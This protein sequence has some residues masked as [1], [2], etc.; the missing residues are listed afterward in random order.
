[1]PFRCARGAFTKNE[2][3]R[4]EEL[5]AD[6]TLQLVMERDGIT[7]DIL[8]A[9]ARETRDRARRSAGRLPPNSQGPHSPTD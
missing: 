8:R 5:L 1:M 9:L 6:E 4:L 7:P 2:E 3:P